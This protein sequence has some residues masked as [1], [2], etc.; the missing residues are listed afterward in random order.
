MMDFLYGVAFG[1]V[2]ATVILIFAAK[3]F[4]REIEKLED[5]WRANE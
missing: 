4:R 3:W 1:L 5:E 2:L